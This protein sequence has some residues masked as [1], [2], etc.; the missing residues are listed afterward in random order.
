MWLNESI[1][2]RSYTIILTWEREKIGFLNLFV[3]SHEVLSMHQKQG[4]G[5]N[6]MTQK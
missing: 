6:L 4:V 3:F 1:T 5:H 2:H